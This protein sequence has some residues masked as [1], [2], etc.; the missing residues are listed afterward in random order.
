MRASGAAVEL[1][2]QD[3]GTGIPPDELPRLFERFHRV[4]NARGRTP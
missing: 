3:T 4:E 2:V 1:T